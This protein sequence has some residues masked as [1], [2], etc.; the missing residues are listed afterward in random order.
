MNSVQKTDES[1]FILG[2]LSYAV[3]ISAFGVVRERMSI[4]I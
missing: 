1:L 4:A 2:T 3:L